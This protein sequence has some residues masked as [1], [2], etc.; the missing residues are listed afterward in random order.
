MDLAQ[1]LSLGQTI[2]NLSRLYKFRTRFGLNVPLVAPEDLKGFQERSKTV[3]S[4]NN[5]LAISLPNANIWTATHNTVISPSLEI[6]GRSSGTLQLFYS[7]CLLLAE[8]FSDTF[9]SLF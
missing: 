8:V 1:F 3:C 2:G 4:L 6:I 9:F 5:S 7:S